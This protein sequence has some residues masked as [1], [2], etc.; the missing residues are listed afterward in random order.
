MRHRKPANLQKAGEGKRSY[1]F[2]DGSV[3]G[4]WRAE[5]GQSGNHSVSRQA[6]GPVRGTGR[7][8]ERTPG[9]KWFIFNGYSH[10]FF[11][12]RQA[13]P[14]P[15]RKHTRSGEAFR[16]R[17]W[18]GS[19]APWRAGVKLGPCVFRDS[20]AC[21]SGRTSEAWFA[22]GERRPSESAYIGW[23]CHRRR[24][25]EGGSQRPHEV[26]GAF[27]HVSSLGGRFEKYAHVFG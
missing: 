13:P 2:S 23:I 12:R 22:R 14:S 16:F 15:P 21:C 27:R 3:T 9:G 17:A 8:W 11:R 20:R 10:E 19:N 18:V 4:P 6:R 7:F 5:D 26:F 25:R 1:S 24:Q